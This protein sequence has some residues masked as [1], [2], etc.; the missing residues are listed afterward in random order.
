MNTD[1]NYDPTTYDASEFPPFAV[2]ADLC[3]FTIRNGE[4][5]LLL[6]ER[7]GEPFKGSW[8][9]PGGFLQPN[10][11]A[12][13]AAWRELYEETGVGAVT[14]ANIVG[15]ANSLLDNDH[16]AMFS[17]H[18]DN[19][20]SCKAALVEA[21]VEVIEGDDINDDSVQLSRSQN[22]VVLCRSPFEVPL[23]Y[24]D[25]FFHDKEF[26]LEQ[27]KTYSAP[28]RD[29]R[30]RVVSVAYVAMAPDLPDPVAGDDAASA[31]WW[32]V[33]DLLDDNGPVLAFDHEQ[34]IKD[35]LE[36]VR[37]KLEYTT[38][39]LQ[40]VGSSF[41]LNDLWR[42]YKTVWGIEPDLA[43]FRRKVLSIDGF[44]VPTSE[45]GTSS[46]GPRPLLYTAGTAKDIQPAFMRPGG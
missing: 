5:S 12:E 9:L 38:L 43:N 35:A 18:G 34:I 39:A 4:L 46:G 27:L 33:A 19:Y 17:L 11:D 30:M 32:A 44:V 25:E 16:K 42:V 7:G 2:T 28:N 24:R 3:I 15:I 10:E 31:R 6:V 14:S 1:P 41:T 36:R 22:K 20:D 45:R 40:F 26:H 13:T 23:V 29:P 21:G 8:A 37:S